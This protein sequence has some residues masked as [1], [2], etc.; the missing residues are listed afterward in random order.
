MAGRAEVA[1]QGE[2]RVEL[3]RQIH[4][5]EVW[6]GIDSSSVHLAIER[7]ELKETHEVCR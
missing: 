4:D 3:L 2:R 1:S 7:G 6:F 5:Y